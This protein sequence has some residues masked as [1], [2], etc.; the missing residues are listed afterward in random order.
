[1]DTLR[2]DL[3][4]ALRLLAKSPGFS[5][6]V[7]LTLALGIGANTATKA[8]AP[9]G[10]LLV[11][12]SGEAKVALVNPANG[13]AQVLLPSGKGPHEITASRDGA[14]A[15]VAIAGTGPQGEPGHTITVIDV[16][17]RSVKSTFELIGCRQ[18]HDTRISRDGTLLWVACAPA[19]GVLEL[20]ART[21]ERHRM[22]KTNLDGGWFVEVT[23]DER[24][25]YVPHLEG[26]ALSVIDRSSGAARAVHS[27]TAQ[28]SIAISPDGREVWAADSDEHKLTIVDTTTDQVTGSVGLGPPLQGQAAFARLRFT[29]DGRHVAVVRG[30]KFIVLDAQERSL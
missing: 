9:R 27:G 21:G 23:P 1:M 29:P 17:R 25:L 4:Y 15:F 22:L 2:Q 10:T 16:K 13:E 12:Y 30:A 6:V 28:F 3:R 19:Q 20:D 11:S 26:K 5:A 14:I 8:H 7:V 24:K 18:P